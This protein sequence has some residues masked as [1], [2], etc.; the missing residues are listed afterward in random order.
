MML[1]WAPTAPVYCQVYEDGHEVWSGVF[2]PTRRCRQ[3]AEIRTARP[4]FRGIVSFDRS[5]A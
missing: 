3:V 5:G 4:G 2:I 1:N